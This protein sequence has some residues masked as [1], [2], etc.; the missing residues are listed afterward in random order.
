MATTFKTLNSANDVTSTRTLLHEAIPLTGTIA[1]GTYDENN[2]YNFYV[3]IDERGVCPE[4][5]HVATEDDILF[6]FNHLGGT[7]I[8]GGKLKSIGTI[9]DGDG[10]WYSPNV[11]S[12]ESDFNAIPSGRYNNE[13]EY[14]GYSAKYWTSSY[15]QGFG[16]DGVIWDLYH[17]NTS[18]SY[19][20]AD[21]G[22]GN[23]I[24][25]LAD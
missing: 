16:G 5:F 22:Y 14:L 12:N 9:E 23:S 15:A 21:D 4:G 13:L 1:S 7:E 2:I 25:C 18:V 20:N 17:S 6:L 3:A 19:G 11:A 24:R 8:A 10:L